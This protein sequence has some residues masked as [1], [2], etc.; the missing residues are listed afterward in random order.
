MVL[1]LSRAVMGTHFP[2]DPRTDAWVATLPVAEH[3]VGPAQFGLGFGENMP[4][5]I[6]PFLEGAGVRD[7]LLAPTPPF[8]TGHFFVRL[9][10]C[11]A[12][13]QTGRPLAAG[14]LWK[15]G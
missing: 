3:A 9:G 15:Q 1:L 11:L 2:E 10:S 4:S 13:R 7:P 8:G 14:G 12:L 6:R 5:R